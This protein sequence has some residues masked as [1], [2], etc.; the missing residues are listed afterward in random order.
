MYFNVS[1]P[2]LILLLRLQIAHGAGAGATA[3]AAGHTAEN[4]G[5]GGGLM[6]QLP[7]PRTVSGPY[8]S[9]VASVTEHEGWQKNER[10]SP[11]ETLVSA[12]KEPTTV[13][14][15]PSNTRTALP[16][17]V[18]V[19]ADGKVPVRSPPA[20]RPWLLELAPCEVY[21]K[22]I[23]PGLL[24]LLRVATLH[25]LQSAL[26]CRLHACLHSLHHLHHVGGSWPNCW[27]RCGL[28]LLLLLQL[29]Y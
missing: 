13:K 4:G 1:E 25:C 9:P 5:A 6:L 28:L 2:S 11:T 10:P 17:M 12:E 22:V 20:L 26:H 21:L 18:S 3:G 23:V 15:S 16:A 27:C 14:T 7:P 19:V 24:L 8:L 29:G